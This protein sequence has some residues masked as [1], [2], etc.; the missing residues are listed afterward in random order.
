M[1]TITRRPL[2]V[3]NARPDPKDPSTWPQDPSAKKMR[4]EKKKDEPVTVAKKEYDS[5]KHGYKI[6]PPPK[7]SKGSGGGSD[8]RKR[9]SSGKFA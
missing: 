8:K 5:E 3:S 2:R 6:P 4:G 1:S 7:E 9:D